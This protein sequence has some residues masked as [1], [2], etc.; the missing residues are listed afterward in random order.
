MIKVSPGCYAKTMDHIISANKLETIEIQ[1]KT[2]DWAGELTD[3]FRGRNSE[4]LHK[5][6]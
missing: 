4:T 6:I 1:M 5:V 2:M 3:L